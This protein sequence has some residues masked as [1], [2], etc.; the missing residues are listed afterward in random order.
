MSVVTDL[1]RAKLVSTPLIAITTPDQLATINEIAAAFEHVPLVTYDVT[2]GPVGLNPS[3]KVAAQQVL[4]DEMERERFCD[5][6]AYAMRHSRDLA[7]DGILL[8]LNAQRHV[9]DGRVAQ[10]I[11]LLRDMYKADGRT[12]VMLAPQIIFP[13]ELSQDVLILDQPLPDEQELEGV[14]LSVYKDT[15]DCNEGLD[16]PDP[17]TDLCRKAVE[18]T[19]G[20]HRFAAE[21]AF[22]YS[23]EKTGI[24][25]N[26]C[27]S[28]KRA[29]I[30][31]TRGL[32]FYRGGET[33]EEIGGLLQFKQ[34]MRDLYEGPEPM[35]VIV[36]LD[37]IE[38]TMTGTTGYGGDGGVSAD[39]LNCVLTNIEDNGWTGC[40]ALGPPG[41]GKSI[42]AKATGNTF[43]I[44][45]IRM[46]L[47]AVKGS[48]V[49]ESEQLIRQMMKVV[50]G[51][52]GN[53]AFFI[54]TCNSLHSLPLRPAGPG[55][56]GSDLEDQP[57]Q[58]RPGPQAGDAG[59]RR[60]D[61]LGHSQLLP[62]CLPE[63][64]HP[65]PGQQPD[66]A[67]GE[68]EPRRTDAAAVAGKRQVPVGLLSRT[69]LHYRPRQPVQPGTG[70]AAPT[71]PRLAGRAS[72]TRKLIL[73]A[74]TSIW[75]GCLF[76]KGN[77]ATWKLW[78]PTHPTLI[79]EMYR[80]ATEMQLPST[81]AA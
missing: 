25:L 36:W 3:G 80:P 58:V 9:L 13:P 73:W 28:F 56:E 77:V 43:N 45:C 39:Q 67:R 22:V 81:S 61:R 41:A 52:A 72:R 19:A 65:D 42:I 38:K 30:E 2:Q 63:A 50:Y 44:P 59:R 10:G 35:K 60:L 17:S 12:L 23:M 74:P 47:G 15:R 27:W 46:D 64:A 32:F 49:G 53:G 66:R 20:L 5:D 76:M 18:A 4:K 8:F 6:P 79:G 71:R 48:L 62:G 34:E 31:Q 7:E 69:V 68:A 78:H 40:I 29:A 33:Y 14:L 75:G 1:K 54:A 21:Q 24:D 70:T 51:I 26:R 55:G 11:A 16:L 37:E 57:R